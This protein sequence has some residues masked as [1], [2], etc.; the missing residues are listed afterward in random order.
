MPNI[1]MPTPQTVLLVLGV[2]LFFT[3]ALFYY[4]D[5]KL[6]GSSFILF[7][8]LVVMIGSIGPD[9]IKE[10]AFKQNKDGTEM[11]LTPAIDTPQKI[12]NSILVA[13]KIERGFESYERKNIVNFC[14][15]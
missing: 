6:A 3:A 14:V 5:K 12:S 10:L 1:G 11:S 15:C 4:K 2:T 8:F 13:R 9:S 7:A